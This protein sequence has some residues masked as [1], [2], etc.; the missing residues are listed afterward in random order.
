MRQFRSLADDRV[1]KRF[2]PAIL[3]QIHVSFSEQKG[4][5]I[6]AR[7]IFKLNSQARISRESFWSFALERNFPTYVDVTALAARF[8]CGS[9]IQSVSWRS[10]TARIGGFP[11]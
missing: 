1:E 6:H 7:N 8:S 4:S 2:A 11:V 10:Y 5:C 9:E 3:R